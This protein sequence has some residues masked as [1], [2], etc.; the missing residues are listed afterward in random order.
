MR[1]LI[2]PARIALHSESYLTEAKIKEHATA[3]R[4]RLRAH[5]GMRM[6]TIFRRPLRFAPN[7]SR[8][9][10]AA[11][12]GSIGPQS[13][14]GRFVRRFAQDKLNHTLKAADY[15]DFIEKLLAALENKAG[16]LTSTEAKNREGKPTRLYQLKLTEVIWKPG[17]GQTVRADAVKLRAYKSSNF[18]R[19]YFSKAFIAAITASE[20]C[21]LP[22]TIPANST[23]RDKQDR[24]DRFRAEWKTKD[25]RDDES[26]TAAAPSVRCSARPRWSW[27]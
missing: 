3:F 6:R 10:V 21:C 15:R 9:T 7:R 25:G 17:D 12:R 24:E 27:G 23:T 4:E 20:S 2:F 16:Y 22:P 14:Y 1:R 8:V 18:V 5:G 11:R 19:I 26:E 13:G